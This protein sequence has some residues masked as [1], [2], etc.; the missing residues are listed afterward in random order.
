MPTGGGEARQ[1]TRSASTDNS[2]R[3]SPDGQWIAFRSTRSGGSQIWLLPTSGGEAR[4]VTDLSTGA[5]GPMWMP[6]GDRIVFR[7]RVFPDCEDDDCNEER[8]EEEENSKVKARIYDDLLY[9]HW[10]E[11]RDDRRGHIFVTSLDGDNIHDLT[12]GDVDYP[13]AALGS[14]HDY[15]ISPDGGEICVTANHNEHLER[16][17][18]NDLFVFDIK[19]GTKKQITK[20]EANDNHPVYSPDGKYIAY[21]AM[22]RPG[23][24]ADRYRL[25]LYTRKSGEEIDL[26]DDLAD[27]LDRSVRS[28]TWAPNGKHIYVTC[29]D[30]GYVSI[31]RV[32]VP[33]GK[34]TQ[35]TRKIYASNPCV[36]PK[37]KTIVFLKQ[38]ATA[39]YEV[40]RMDAKGGRIAQLS[41][42]NNDIL[43]SVDMNPVE[44]FS[45][46]GAENTEVNGFLV[47]PPGFDDGKTYPLVFLIHG[48]PQGAWSD[49][50]HMRWNYQM[51]AAG[52]YVIAAV[53]PR[54]ST[55]YGQKFTDE[56][57]QDWGGKVYEDL[58]LGL[59]HVLATYPFIDGE[60]IAAAGGSYGG[61]MVN[62]IAGHT[63]RFNCLVNH[64]GVYNFTSFYGTTEEL[65]F[66]E[67]DFGG[68]PW[69]NRQKYQ[70]YSPHNYA[71]NFKTPML[72]IHGGKDY[73]VDPSEGFQVYTALQRQGVPSRLLYFPDEGHWVLKPLN[74]ELWWKTV[75][76]WLGEWLKEG[77]VRSSQ[78]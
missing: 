68:T 48:G 65:W 71:E 26:G 44:E 6:D 66:P 15:A 33:G 72:V 37:G 39:P 47:K 43:S 9:R 40:F 12:P 63:D 52:G 2:P 19:T 51:F 50:F 31:Y 28:I 54:G 78:R 62:W 45:F 75:H 14:G 38:S 1:L 16:N 53:N 20:N 24:E 32:D 17:I 35:L 18:D 21:R 34:T 70:R 23:F 13:T 27:T 10:D 42:V 56:I 67:W 22:T 3:F 77:A 69:E 49:N 55:G 59:D 76:E 25:R 8:L 7:S 29:S 4:Q 36:S 73:R 58:M 5:S 60:R 57:S 41:S 30:Q 64:D 11:W 74:A 61:Y 46:Q